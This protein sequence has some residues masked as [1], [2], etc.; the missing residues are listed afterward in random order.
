MNIFLPR[1]NFK[2]ISGS[3]IYAYIH[4]MPFYFLLWLLQS[5]PTSIRTVF[6]QVC[7]SCIY[8][9]KSRTSL[10]IL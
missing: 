8:I 7:L 5:K 4:L 2:S 1:F 10:Y 6:H 3:V 9:Q